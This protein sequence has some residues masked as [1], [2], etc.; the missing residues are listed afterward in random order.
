MCAMIGNLR[1]KN[2][3]KTVKFFNKYFLKCI[4]N[5]L[6]LSALPLCT[7]QS[8]IVGPHFLTM[9]CI[10]LPPPQGR[11]P[12]Q[13]TRPLSSRLLCSPPPHLCHHYHEHKNFI[14]YSETRVWC[15]SYR[16][17]CTSNLKMSW[18]RACSTLHPFFPHCNIVV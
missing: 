4:R 18:L 7:L 6:R 11:N 10:F 17:C 16:C 1:E 12:G 2:I 14:S 3:Q 8:I 9:C 15:P 13:D 5:L